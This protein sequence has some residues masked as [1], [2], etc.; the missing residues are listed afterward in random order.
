[1]AGGSAELHPNVATLFGLST[2]PAFRRR[3][4]QAALIAAR[5]ERARAAGISLATIGSEPGISTE[6][7]AMRLGFR[8]AYT[9]VVL[10][11]P[12]PGLARSP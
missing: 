10:R 4:V 5:L 8:V 6:R 7:N 3:G 12:E 1:V 9:K 2:L 11:K